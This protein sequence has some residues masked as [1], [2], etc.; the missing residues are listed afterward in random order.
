MTRKPSKPASDEG[1]PEAKRAGPAVVA[2]GASAGG[3][4]A[5]QNLFHSLPDKL[6]VAYVVILH[7]APEHRSELASVLTTQTGMP[8]TAVGDPVKVEPDHVYVIPPDRRLSISDHEIAAL[9][10]DEPRGR[11]A[12]VDSFFRSMAA[13][14][15]DG[16]AIVLSGAGSD[17]SVGVRA[18]KE[19]GGI[20]LVQDPGEAEY[21][22]MPR[23]AIA[24]G[25]ADFVLPVRQMA[26]RLAELVQTGKAKAQAK[27]DDEEEEI[28]RILAHLRVRTGHDF[29]RY[30]RSTIVRR[31]QR[32]VQVARKDG[33]GDYYGY[34]R[35]NAEEAQALFSDL[36]IS[37]T[38]FFRDP[39]AF[40]VLAKEVIPQVF[41]QKAGDQIRVWVPGCAT[42]EE[43]YS[44]GMLLLEEAYRRDIRPD[45][46][47]FGSD[48]DATALA[49]AREGRYPIAIEADVSD[50]RLRRFFTRESDHFRIKR[51]LRDIVLFASHSLLRDPPFSRI[52]LISCRNLLIYLN[53]ELQN[54]VVAV[55]HY[56]LNPGGY[57]FMGSSE[58]A[59]H[60][61]QLF[62][63][64]DREAHLFQSVTGH[65]DK[66]QM[67][68]RL[69]EAGG[70]T[71]VP[72]RAP[73]SAGPGEAAL[74][75]E[76]L[77]QAAP[78]SILVDAS[79]RALHLSEKAG[80]YLLHARGPISADIV[81]LARPELRLDLR[82]AL[83]RAFERGETTLSMPTP[84]RFNGT[85]HR[86]QL[87]VRPA[88]QPDSRGGAHA[89]V[90][91]LEGEAIDEATEAALVGDDDRGSS[92]VVRRLAEELRLTQ[93]RLRTTREESE[94]ANEELRAANEE[95]QSIN[96]EYRSTSEE[97]ETSKEELQSVNEELQTVNNELK[98]KL[99][100]VS[101][102][103]S[104]LQNLMAATDV[105]TL[106]L[107]SALRIKRFTPRLSEL[108][109]VT[110]NDEGRPITDFTHQ[111][112]YV[113]LA[114]DV[115]GVLRNLTTV[116]R[117]VRAGDGEWHLMRIRP[118]RT[119]DDRIDGVVVTFVDITERRRIEQAL[120]DSELRLRN[121]MRLV[122]A[123]RSPIFVWDMDAGV[124]Q[125][126]RGCEQLYGFT[127]EE[128]LGKDPKQLLK[129]DVPGSTMTAV[130]ETL[131]EAGVWN[132][133]LVQTARDGRKLIVE[134]G[135]EL[136]PVEGRRLVMESN[137]DVSDRK[138]W[139]RQQ[140]LML[141][142]LSHRVKNT[143]A[144]VQSFASQSIRGSH[145]ASE[146]TERFDGRL[147][148][149][150]KTHQLLTD[151]WKGADIQ[152]LAR[153]QLE[154]YAGDG[155]ERLKL[156][157]GAFRLPAD[158][159]VP[160]GLV[161]HELATNAVKHGALSDPK[162]VIE[163]GW[164]NG[165]K[166]GQRV[167]T[168]VWK[169]RNGPPITE[170]DTKGF[171]SRLIERGLPNAKVTRAFN[172]QGLTVTIEAPLPE[173]GD[174]LES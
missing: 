8:V 90:M 35:E 94:A 67:L 5:L 169:E 155:G 54:Q 116:E 84:V 86:V 58:S 117:E 126:N 138:D 10:F 115:R 171:G 146:F 83:H 96:E 22:S 112:D 167:L 74:H 31:L 130:L 19:A 14:H 129:T 26:Q 13:Q 131:T 77:E 43:A 71:T 51:D 114:K 158:L 36:L 64:L 1:A 6:G 107:D 25:V 100:S 154:P 174:G 41:D 172:P 68:P 95:L 37:V 109:N 23:S 153:D 27:R 127:S 78:P 134:S 2:I 20:I 97:L 136:A 46:Q 16:Y 48:L 76:S 164:K 44:I 65:G 140:Q 79:H 3:I 144:V 72:T 18:V 59:D 147:A 81:E 121:E 133:E 105:G 119:V 47:V 80:R 143:L 159:A 49:T 69:I 122:D 82:A 9:P 7:L 170:P 98:L 61:G 128:A 145:S 161:L 150:A 66:V 15:G 40:E 56:A 75:R 33:L 28:R 104:D 141:A 93:E 60:P 156:S 157:G 4:K 70:A 73:L 102:A 29:S 99:E 32:R 85:T 173:G 24:T 152:S 52:D 63:T 123:S 149:L 34:L 21:P 12:P 118:Y 168:L 101:R 30:K 162:G 151:P 42:G 103:N 125:W 53:R 135:M 57:L 11:R 50:E 120:R 163:L 88:A 106:F 17:G 113:D 148:A 39:R 55:F 132:G 108:F 89:L 92:E 142:E 139:E 137:R 160:L 91:F 110:V 165:R 38:T 111:L 166:D 87:Q 62:R 45:I 124:V